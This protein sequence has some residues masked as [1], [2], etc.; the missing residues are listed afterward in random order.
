MTAAS[1]D[2]LYDRNFLLA[3]V[4]QTCFVAANTLMAHY[5][6][7]IEFLGG[8]LTNVGW[9]MGTGSVLGLLVR[10][11]MAGWINRL[12]ARAMW[13]IGY[14]LFA[15]GS[16]ANL[17]VFDVGLG[18][19]VIRSIL[20]IGTAIVFASGLTYI[21]QTA[22][23][24]RRTEAIGIFGIGGFLGM[25]LGPLIGDLFL[26]ERAREN[27][28]WLFVLA[29]GACI[30]PAIGLYFLRPVDSD[31]PKH[32]V[33]LK[34]FFSIVRRHWP[35]TILLVDLV[36]GVCMAGPFIFVASFIDDAKLQLPGISIIGLFFL[37]YAGVG[38][39]VRLSL[40]RLPDQIG[41]SKVLLAG[42]LMMSLGM[43]SF[44]LVHTGSPWL[45]LIP[46][47]VAGSGHGLMFH[48]MTSLTLERFPHAV[49]GTGSALALVMLDLGTVAGAPMLGWIGREFGFAMLFSTIGMLCLI[50]GITYALSCSQANRSL[51]DASTTAVRPT[52]SEHPEPE[53]RP[54]VDNAA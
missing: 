22:P 4:S 17:W 50:T 7:W 5:A 38:T 26:A 54:S 25:M 31:R 14:V 16:L 32:A 43:F 51:T 48:T 9:V 33:R 47:V 8:D 30:L 53:D 28:A 37:F 39:T 41:A 18:I 44:A 42:M 20:F 13:A 35:G 23:D 27:F 1:T 49:R 40:R 45:I 2:R 11:W 24:H 10:P 34:E 29:A 15:L 36:F 12:G 6:R 52:S 19:Y 21:T 3:L 46:A